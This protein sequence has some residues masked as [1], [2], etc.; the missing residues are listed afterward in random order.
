MNTGVFSRP[1]IS[2]GVVGM[3]CFPEHP[4]INMSMMV[5]VN[6]KNEET[7]DMIDSTGKG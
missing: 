3:F 4:Q 5:K 6:I 1:D 7:L 2:D